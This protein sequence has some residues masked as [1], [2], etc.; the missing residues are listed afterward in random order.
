M[1]AQHSQFASDGW[2]NWWIAYF[3]ELATMISP[4][5]NFCL[6]LLD[7]PF[8]NYATRVRYSSLS[9][10]RIVVSLEI[11]TQTLWKGATDF[12]PIYSSDERG[13]NIVVGDTMSPHSPPS[14]FSA[15]YFHE[16]TQKDVALE[17][18]V[19]PTRVQTYR[20]VYLFQISPYVRSNLTC[21]PRRRVLPRRLPKH[22]L[23]SLP[24]Q[25]FRL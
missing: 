18:I 6:L 24:R 13:E 1:C 7:I 15:P 19:V 10:Q 3:E 17:R 14:L 9:L 25:I 11:S 16:L 8:S 2:R 21:N 12:L 4:Q 5:T 22:H 20:I 23:K